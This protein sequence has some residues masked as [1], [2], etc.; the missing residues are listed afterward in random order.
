[1]VIQRG[2]WDQ[3]LTYMIA[4]KVASSLKYAQTHTRTHTHIYI[5]I[6]ELILIVWISLVNFG[7]FRGDHMN[8]LIDVEEFAMQ[9]FYVVD[10]QKQFVSCQVHPCQR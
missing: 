3:E 10:S 1:M 7:K 2:N 4:F 5:Y 9:E 6:H 8:P